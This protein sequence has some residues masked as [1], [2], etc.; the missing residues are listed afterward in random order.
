MGLF[1]CISFRSSAVELVSGKEPDRQGAGEKLR[2]GE[3]LL[4]TRE[5]ASLKPHGKLKSETSLREPSTVLSS[6]NVMQATYII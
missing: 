5:A 2:S 6:G 4:P 1:I 3:F